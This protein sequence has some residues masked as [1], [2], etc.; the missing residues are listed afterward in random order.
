MIL[1]LFLATAAV[2]ASAAPIAP[3]RAIPFRTQT[4]GT[5]ATVTLVTADSSAVADLAYRG[6]L[7][8]H[9]VDSL[10]SNWT[11]TSEVARINRNAGT[12]DV[13]VHFEVALVLAEAARV[14][15]DTG[16]AMDITVE[17]LVR[18]WGFLG[19]KKR[20]PTQDEITRTL[21]SVGPDKVRFD[22]ARRS[23]RF[24]T[25]GTKI[26][27]GGIAKGYG[28]DCVASILREA[29]A[30]D[31]L[32]DLSGNM[33]ALGNAPDKGGWSVGVRDPSGQHPYLGTIRLHDE[34]ISTSGNYEQ[35]VDADGKRYGHIIDPRT[36]WP[37]EGLVSV[38]VVA[39]HAV[40]CDA[41]DTGLF[42]LGSEKA[43][44]LAKSREDISIVVVEPR[45]GGGYVVW[46]EE[47]LRSRFKI[48][49]EVVST[50]TLRYF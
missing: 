40:Q 22:A 14:T 41:W 37:A 7:E 16:G 27:L 29:G 48:E 31:A 9:R 2:A 35:F 23:I 17:P 20:I 46:V 38:T 24:A 50:L 26:D 13:N 36:G 11:Q 12:R 39:A 4:M 25:P 15:R 43:R 33:V 49:S 42:V 21:A 10:M 19:G 44:A 1:H 28:V 6:L 45:S 47:S 3:S 34:A 18:L 30:K 5:W 8:L 32:I